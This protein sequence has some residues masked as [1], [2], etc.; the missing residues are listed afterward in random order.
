MRERYV[1]TPTVYQME[2]T[3]CGA[4]SLAMIFG[5]F[6]R[7]MSSEKMRIETGVSRDGCN[8]GNLMR[9]AKKYGL[10]CHGYRKETCSLIKTEPPCII[11]WN[12]NHFVVFEGIKRGYAYINDP[13]QGRR[14]LSLDE[15]DEAFTGIVLTFKPTDKFERQP[16]NNTIFGFVKDRLSGRG[17]TVLKLLLIG[18]LLVIPGLAIPAATRFILDN[19][20]TNADMRRLNTAIVFMVTFVMIKVFLNFYRGRVLICL[21]NKM[22]LQSAYEFVSHLLRLPI[23]FFEQR[24]A[25]D[26]ADRVENNNNVNNFLSGEL[27]ESVL[28]LIISVFYLTL[29]ILYSPILTLIVLCSAAVSVLT[30]KL[31]SQYLSDISMKTRQD[32]GKLTGALCSGLNIIST[33]KASGAENEY[34]TRILGYFA[35]NISAEQKTNR[36]QQVITVIPQ[37]MSAVTSII[38]LAVGGVSVMNGNMTIGML[39]AFSALADGFEKPVESLV[40]FVR[41][42]HII[43]ADIA[44]VEDVYKYKEDEKFGGSADTKAKMSKLSGETEVKNISFGYSV[45]DEPLI[46]D[47]SFKLKSGESIALIGMSGCGK[48]TVSK[49]LSGLYRPWSGE[50]LFD[51]KS[52]DKIP[53]EVLAASVSCVS[54]EPRIFSGT[55]RENLTMWNS[56]ILESDIIKA[57]KDACIHD[58]ITQKDGAYD[59][60]LSEGGMNLSGGQ[61]QRLEIARALVTNPSVLILDEATSALDA[62]VEK[63]ILDN[64]KKRGCTCLVV[65]HRLTAIRDCDSII[66]MDKGRVV[67]KGSH[68][69]LAAQGGL[70]ADIIKNV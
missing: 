48:S 43:K 69:E 67:Q 37:V 58:I 19:M 4:A 5:Y 27:A 29:M 45:L 53:K 13:A 18:L 51:G 25:G 59:Y 32:N 7:Y 31:G 30:L 11:H 47:F 46:K 35:R 22:I 63:K 28:N 61:R 44:R 66:V 10:E 57:A 54:Q 21:Q 16:E 40:G 52:I 65:A 36:F 17:G 34:A 55:I 20:N 39:A 26:L 9:C 38:I 3:E 12:F 41:R 33:L 14:R 15:L 62:I 2:A 24:Y 23:S 56:G 60:K 49:I 64:I 1:K 8:A 68:R 42:I 6:G 70:Y 50:V